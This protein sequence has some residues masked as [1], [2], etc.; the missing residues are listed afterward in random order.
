MDRQLSLPLTSGTETRPLPPEAAGRV[1]QGDAFDLFGSL[2]PGSVD[3]VITSPPYWG[4]RDYGLEHNWSFF[5]DIPKVRAIGPSTPGY[6]WY[7]SNGGLLGLE[8]YPEWYVAHLADIFAKSRHSLHERG[9]LWINIGDTYFARW[10]SIREQGR[11]GLGTEGRQRRKT[12][13]GGIRQEKQLLLIPARFA[14]EMQARG[15]ILRNDLIWHKPNA[16]PR[17]EGDRLRNTHE[18][19]FHFVKKPKQGRARYYYE[20]SHAEPRGN[21][22]VVVN[23]APGE[24]GHSATFPYDLIEP[25][26]RTS[27]PPGGTVLDPFCGTG[28]ALE[29]ARGLGRRVVGFDAQSKF[30]DLARSKVGG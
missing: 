11:Q 9:S 18:H 27:S 25:R 5:N 23:V 22:V 24:G 14:I 13:L 12:P 3:L 2:P 17:P 21:D 10:A 19:F 7:R 16:V 8:P 1:L 15:W 6:D 30:V 28:R 4:H 29:V 26:I 20:I